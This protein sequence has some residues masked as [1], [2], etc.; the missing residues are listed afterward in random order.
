[1]HAVG[2]NTIGGL[3]EPDYY[4]S[5]AEQNTDPDH[6]DRIVDADAGSD[7]CGE[8]D[9]NSVVDT[10]SSGDVKCKCQPDAGPFPVIS[11]KSSTWLQDA[12]GQAAPPVVS[13]GR[14][15]GRTTRRAAEG[16]E[17]YKLDGA[18]GEDDEVTGQEGKELQHLFPGTYSYNTAYDGVSNALF[19][20]KPYNSGT[21]GIDNWMRRGR[22][23]S[24]TP[25]F[26]PAAPSVTIVRIDRRVWI[27]WSE[28]E[29]RGAG[30]LSTSSRCAGAA[31]ATRRT[32]PRSSTRATC[33]PA[34]GRQKRR[35]T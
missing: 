30:I 19:R 4:I 10:S 2:T 3:N 1:M 11:G 5:F 9:T 33:A 14:R 18:N 28:P 12:A 34:R 29:N 16:P 21:D 7:V 32:I 31:A 8:V 17:K 15:R 27:Q 23:R 20:V 22:P 25:I 6:P 13:S 24:A 26:R 35:S